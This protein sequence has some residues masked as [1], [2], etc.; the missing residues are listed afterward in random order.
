MVPL[1]SAAKNQPFALTNCL[2]TSGDM[3][4]FELAIAK[5]EKPVSAK[6]PTKVG[7][8]K[9]VMVHAYDRYKYVR[10]LDCMSLVSACAPRCVCM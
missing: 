4:T 7:S 8:D 3:P 5:I 10:M 1:P 9:Q 6:H 2:H